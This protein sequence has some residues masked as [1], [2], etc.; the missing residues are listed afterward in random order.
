VNLNPEQL[1]SQIKSRVGN[2]PLCVAYSG[3]VD[4]HVLLH[5]LATYRTHFSQLRAIH[6]DH[7]LQPQS[8]D[9]RLHCQ[10][11]CDELGI[12]F[13]AQSVF[14]QPSG[15]GI[16]AAAREARYQALQSH[17]EKDEIL[18]TAQHADDQVETILL[19]LFRGA[20]PAGLSGMAEWGESNH[21]QVM[22][23]LLD[24]SK[25]AIL[26]YAEQYQLDWIND[27]SNE[28]T[29]F[30]RNFLRH[31]VLPNL[32]TRWKGLN[33]SLARSAENCA[34][35][36]RLLTDLAEIDFASIATHDTSELAI[37]SLIKLSIE[38]QRNV[39]RYA[40]NAHDLAMP[41]KVI[42]ERVLTE[43][44]HAKVDAQ[45]EVTWSGGCIR[46][47]K[48]RLILL[49]EQPQRSLSVVS[50]SST[51][52]IALEDTLQLVW[53]PVPFGVTEQAITKGLRLCYR[54]GGE[55]IKLAG[56]QQHKSLKHCFQEWQVP[57]WQRDQIP[58]LYDGETLVA[59]VGY[60]VAE[61]YTNSSTE[62][63]WEARIEA[64][65]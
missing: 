43:M 47:Y 27:P 2:R 34:E 21:M 33:K 37:S 10:R 64:R 61:G 54:Q 52:T 1:I 44:C 12:T 19:Q 63:G 6:I 57:A 18:F 31:E 38:R 3:G 8:G 22:R 51:K 14:V 59:V 13:L 4:S 28:L 7:Q 26:N 23:P 17:L 41:S 55:R 53:Y 45:P 20:G 24:H 35:A 46:R 30:D 56:H 32:K 39:L 49:D 11:I 58:L 25:A 36:Q 29:H 5:L 42:L 48:D 65:D 9:W 15:K 50:V 16:E 40:I 62:Q 60:A